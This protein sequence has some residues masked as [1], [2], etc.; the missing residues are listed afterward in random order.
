[1]VKKINGGILVNFFKKN[2]YKL[3]VQIED[4]VQAKKYRTYRTTPSIRKVKATR[5][6]KLD[7]QVYNT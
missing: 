2:T 4:R 7:S 5:L 3:Y 1:M 6:R